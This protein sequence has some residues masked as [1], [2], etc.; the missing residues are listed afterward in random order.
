MNKTLW[1][2]LSISMFPIWKQENEVVYLHGYIPLTWLCLTWLLWLGEKDRSRP[3]FAVSPTQ[4]NTQSIYLR[5]A[6]TRL[7]NVDIIV[8]GCNQ[9]LFISIK[10][11][12]EAHVVF[13]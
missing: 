13:I 10:Y 9:C 5:K 7:E 4:M 8:Q 6:E 12:W 1:E 11:F 2:I 3:S